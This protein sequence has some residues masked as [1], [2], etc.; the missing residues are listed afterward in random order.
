[1]R[2]VIWMLAVGLAP[3]AAQAQLGEGY[4]PPQVN[5]PLFEVW[6]FERP[7]I[8]S[9]MVV[10]L[11]T[12]SLIVLNRAGQAKRGLVACAVALLIATALFVSSALVTTQRERVRN[13]TRSLVAA[14]AEPDLL[15]AESLMRETVALRMR[16]GASSSDRGELLAQIERLH[17]EA[18][19]RGAS[20]LDA[21]VRLV[22]DTI[23]TCYARVKVDGSAGGW[24]IPPYSWW[25]LS[26]A[27]DDDRWRLSAIEPL[28][29]TGIENP[30]GR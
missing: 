13:A 29:M 14:V 21:R 15:D 25:E 19:V 3:H 2:V 1:M 7:L 24:P 4:A 11:G 27:R 9:I 10:L 28:W 30:A 26:F 17:A 22:S 5:E 12:A 8:P 16:L 20:V 23:A 6:A 18:D